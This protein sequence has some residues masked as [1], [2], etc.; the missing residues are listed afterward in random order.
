[1]LQTKNI[2]VTVFYDTLSVS[3]SSKKVFLCHQS[4]IIIILLIV[5]AVDFPLLVQKPD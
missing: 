1:M 2:F 4:I 3:Y 5:I